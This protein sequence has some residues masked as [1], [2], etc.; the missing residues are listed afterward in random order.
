MPTV[1]EVVNLLNSTNFSF[2]FDSRYSTTKMVADVGNVETIGQMLSQEK[3][4]TEENMET[5]LL[6]VLTGVDSKL[7]S[8]R[9]HISKYK[10]EH[11]LFYACCYIQEHNRWGRTHSSTLGPL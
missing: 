5:T 1:S 3:T 4:K 7:R 8:I 2:L 9:R 10:L 11:D 6:V